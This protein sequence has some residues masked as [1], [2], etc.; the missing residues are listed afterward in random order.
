LRC[1]ASSGS[2]DANPKAAPAPPAGLDFFLKRR[3]FTF[4]LF[5]FALYSTI[6]GRSFTAL[7][8][9]QE[10]AKFFA[11]VGLEWLHG[12]LPYID[13]WD[14]KPPGIW[15]L[16]ALVFSVFPKNF[17]ALAFSEG[18]FVLGC[19][20][21]IYFLMRRCGAP[22]LVAALAAASAAVACN[23]QVYNEHGNLTE[24]YLL[25]PA[26]LSMYYFIRSAPSFRGG[27]VFL[28]G[29][30]SGVACLFKTVG[31][32]PLFAQLGFAVFLVLIRRRYFRQAISCVATNVAGAL[33]AWLPVCWYFWR[34]S[35]LRELL[36]A[37]FLYNVRYGLAGQAHFLSEPFVLAAMLQPL[38]SLVACA[39]IGLG[40]CGLLFVR[41]PRGWR[42]REELEEYSFWV[43]ALFWLFFD[44]AGVIAGGRNLPHYFLS[45]APSL[46]VC[47]GFT[48]WFM[49]HRTSA[50][51]RIRIAI[52][53]MI[54]GPLLFAQSQDVLEIRGA[55]TKAEDVL[56]VRGLWVPYTSPQ[57]KIAAYLNAVREP[58]DTLFTWDYLPEI[59]F[60]TGMKSPS[61]QMFAF[62]LRDSRKAWKEFGDEILR[63][64]GRAPPAFIVDGTGRPDRKAAGDSVYRDFRQLVDGS[65]VL[66]Y[67][68]DQYKVY[69]H[70]G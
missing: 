7:A 6:L 9:G 62:H 53:L 39:A 67:A 41:L 50:D 20:G 28:A 33:A 47:A 27:N 70:I 65:Y 10:D 11:Y 26:T 57:D 32:A 22:R 24:I 14:N 40:F 51:E 61:R 25:W 5:G 23:L 18:I 2:C 43:L 49:V 3:L 1:K 60:A 48:Y 44:L 52:V 16:V 38:A 42:G 54:V 56:Y 35:A 21:T 55:V 58:G 12:R 17:T 63:D 59:Y 34:H 15:A 69:K 45:L 8:P 31:L 37:S 29:F 4:L 64:L 30:F 13:I 36:D 68:A 19:L 46:S 66:V